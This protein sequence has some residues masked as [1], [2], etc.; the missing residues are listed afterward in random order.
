MIILGIMDITI[1]I[2][3]IL[4]DPYLIS[5]NNL[6]ILQGLSIPLSITSKVPQII[7][8]YRNGS[9]GQLSVFTMFNYLTGSATRVFMMMTEVSDPVIF[10]GFIVAACLNTVLAA[11]MVYY[12]KTSPKT[13]VT[14]KALKVNTLS[15]PKQ[16]RS[17]TQKTPTTSNTPDAPKTAEKPKTP[18]SPGTP[19]RKGRGKKK[20]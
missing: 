10:W 3:Y 6:K 7:S 19:S 17:K 2:I 15:T 13:P 12:W 9:T 18:R 8:N 4:F 1:I 14:A 20:S 16:T 5:Y 11:Q